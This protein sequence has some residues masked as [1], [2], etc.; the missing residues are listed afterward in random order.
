LI[1]ADPK[2]T[3]VS[4]GGVVGLVWPAAIV[5]IAGETATFVGSVLLSATVT[6]SEGAGAGNVIFK[7]VDWPGPNVTVEGNPMVPALMTVTAAVVSAIIGTA[8]A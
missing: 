5:T 6:P 3:P 2:S 4:C 7:S 1:V 8:L